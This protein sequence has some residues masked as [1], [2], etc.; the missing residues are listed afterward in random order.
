MH[1]HAVFLSLESSQKELEGEID[2]KIQK[3]QDEQGK[4]VLQ[5]QTRKSEKRSRVHPAKFHFTGEFP[6]QCN[7]HG[8]LGI[9]VYHSQQRGGWRPFFD[10]ENSFTELDE[11]NMS[12]L[13][14][15]SHNSTKL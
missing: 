10:N 15:R 2:K 8:S 9:P 5:I 14:R 3:S 6:P 7:H 4:L 13:P 1:E 12:L 11:N